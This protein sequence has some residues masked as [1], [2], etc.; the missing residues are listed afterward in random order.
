[1]VR[2]I[3]ILLFVVASPGLAAGGLKVGLAAIDITP[4]LKADRP[5]WMAGQENGRKATGVHDPLYARALVLRDT[6]TGDKLALVSL[7]VIGAQHATVERIRGRLPGFRYV[8]VA[9]THNHEGP[10][11]IGIWGPDGKSGCDAAYLDQLV[12]RAT[13]A[14]LKAE[15][16]LRPAKARY[17]SAAHRELLKDFRLPE[18]FDDALRVLVFEGDDDKPCGLLV[19]WNSH[20]VE[21]DGNTELTR[22]FF[23]VTVDTLEKRFGCPAIYFSG[24]VGGLMGT[25]EPS[26]FTNAGRPAPKS[27]RQYIDGLGQATADAAAEAVESAR[28]I[29]LTPFRVAAKTVAVPLANKG[30]RQARAAGI[31]AREAFRP[32]QGEALFAD[33]LP[34]D[35]LAG[36]QVCRS[37]VAYLR[38]GELEVAGIP[39]ELYP[40]LVHGEFP[41]SPE[42]G[43]DYPEAPLEPTIA[44]ALGGEKWLVIG[45]ANDELGY[46]IPKR[47]WDEAAPYAYGRGSPQYGERNSMGPE[48][49]RVLME[50]LAEV[51]HGDG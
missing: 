28:A 3:L 42:A 17:A 51:A 33:A 46:I 47:Q 20:P 2:L 39:G 45:L 43:V 34:P 29:R 49:A 24:A 18:V 12:E 10:D 9:S 36:Q 15:S 26:Y 21:P 25:P 11:V 44:S 14:V 8:L 23:G 37:E 4:E 50:A 48:T 7:D 6:E 31:L 38:L 27:V 35:E 1:M 22:D 40:E 16:V 19:Q 13:E 32:G 5:V 41:Q 30:Y